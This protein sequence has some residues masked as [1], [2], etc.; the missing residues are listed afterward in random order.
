MEHFGDVAEAFRD[1]LLELY[2][3]WEDD[4]LLEVDH[5]G[6]RQLEY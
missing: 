6:E 1:H 3:F 2:V 5:A 4:T